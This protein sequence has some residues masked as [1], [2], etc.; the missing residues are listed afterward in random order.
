MSQNTKYSQEPLLQ[1][2]DSHAHLNHPDF[3]GDVEEIA[4]KL[5]KEN[6]IVLNVAYDLESAEKAITL[7]KRFSYMKASVGIHPHD[8]EGVTPEDIAKIKQ[9]SKDETIVAIGETGLDYFRN[10]SSKESQKSVFTQHLKIAGEAGKPVIIHC[11]DAFADAVPIIKKHLNKKAGG[12][13]HCFA[14]DA[15]EAKIGMELGLHIS[16]AGNSTYKKAENLRRAVAVVTPDRLLIETDCPYLAPQSKR[17]KRNEPTY[18]QETA[19]TLAEARGVTV[20]DIA[21]GTHANYLS[22]FLKQTPETAE[23]VYKIRNSLYLNVTRSCSNLCSF[24][25]RESSP[26]VQGHY[27]GVDKDPTAEEII[28][29]IGDRKPDELIFCG[30]GE[31][32]IRLEVIKEVA[33]FAKSKKLKTRLNTNGHGSLIAGR[34]IVPE[35]LGLIDVVSVSLNAS[36]KDDYN[37]L[38][39]PADPEK[40]YPALLEFIK[41]SVEVM[42]STIVTA[43]DVPTGAD[44]DGVGKIAKELGADFRLRSFN[45]VG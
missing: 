18:L 38:C 41:R 8:A 21:R 36:T 4:D 35:L 14:E 1:W 17:G 10:S 45:M 43:V 19:I 33:K 29:A 27:L 12:V 13:F 23:I 32:T 25:S 7:A 6:F 20:D 3:D 34:D 15:E 22:L 42:P 30:F 5:L 11:R 2:A 26:I 24:C 28:D 40:A 31:P 44:I 16:F 39:N 9:L 37:K